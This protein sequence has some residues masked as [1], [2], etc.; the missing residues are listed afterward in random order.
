MALEQTLAE[1][2][3]FSALTKRELKRVASLVTPVQVASGKVLTREGEAGREFMVIA[4]GKAIVSRED[5]EIARLGPGDFFG[6]LALVLGAPRTATVTAGT[7]MIVNT[8]NRREFTSLLD[9]SPQL[10]KRI[11]VGAMQRLYEL[12]C[13]RHT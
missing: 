4:D 9:E 13:T 3:F 6:E 11:L 7:D 2:D 5:H 1:I 10:A 8:L 12:D